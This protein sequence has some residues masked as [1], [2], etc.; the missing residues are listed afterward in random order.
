M[1]VPTD[2]KVS[3]RPIA[4]L[5]AAAFCS[6]ATMRVA[7]PML[8]DIA[9]E[10]AVSVG[11]A[12]VVATAFALA[13]G[14]FQL[15]YGPLGDRFG[16]YGVIVIGMFMSA[17]AV[18]AAA[19]ADSLSQLATL[20][21]VAGAAAASVIP[22]A[23]AY[24]GDI[25]PY[26]RRQPVLARFLSGQILG[27]LFG[28][29]AGG[30]IIELMSWRQ[31]F[32]LLGG[33]F[34][35]IA[36]ALWAEARSP[37]VVEVRS[38]RPLR[39][40][41]IVAQYAAIAAA[42]QARLVLGAV[43]AEG[44][45]FFGGLAYIGAYLRHDFALAYTTIGLVLGCFG[46]GGLAYALTAPRVV[47]FLG[48][49][50]MVRVGSAFL[51]ASFCS[52]AVLPGWQFAAPVTATLGI[53]FYLFHN[54]L[55]TNATQMAPGARGAAVSLFAFCFF[56]GQA[57]GVAAV[58]FAVDRVGYAPGFIASGLGLFALGVWFGGTKRES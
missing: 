49:R 31:A 32:L 27:V 24:I 56:L 22:L 23:M 20:R 10:F 43:F 19:I 5:S 30:M 40:G 15:V 25:I 34:A 53:G 11:T 33:A 3:L 18:S 42:P 45:L 36:F 29:A 50:G 16:K 13:Y 35:V 52:L 4:L 17:V 2:A 21:F 48:E 7:D 14:V 26:E 39:I 47:A 57:A 41:S 58:G 54:T 9:H 51:G 8:P 28:Q 44:C 1:T 6:A 55:Q 46:L 37:R 38:N 12:S